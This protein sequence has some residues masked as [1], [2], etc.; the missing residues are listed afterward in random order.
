MSAMSVAPSTA[1]LWLTIGLAAQAAPRDA[2]ALAEALADDDAKTV[3]QA[4]SEARALGD[5]AM[6]APLQ[7]ALREWSTDPSET[8]CFVQAFVLDALI[9]LHAKVPASE[10]LP[11]LDEERTGAAAFLLL[12][13]EPRQNE[14]ELLE[15]FRRD[16][17]AIHGSNRVKEMRTWAIGNLLCQ[18]RAPGFA[19][20]LLDHVDLDLHVTV[21][22]REGGPA[23]DLPP[24]RERLQLVPRSTRDF[25]NVPWYWLTS[26]RQAS[27]ELAPGAPSI[28]VVRTVLRSPES[29][30]FSFVSNIPNDGLPWLRK[31]ARVESLPKRVLELEFTDPDQ[32][33]RDVATA[34]RGLADLRTALLR[35]LVAEKAVNEQDAARWAGTTQVV[36]DDRRPDKSKRLPTIPAQ[37][38]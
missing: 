21:T 3:A 31:L 13:R 16:W 1:V 27:E 2:K 29:L 34:R 28:G 24:P 11:L 36:I 15:L 4:A 6:V 5:K 20:Y 25:P 8:A 7:H 23:R 10:L 19:A 38:R 12:A 30:R 33:M 17:P 22:S 9:G 18:Q 32:Y 35:G 14:A 37:D 26:D